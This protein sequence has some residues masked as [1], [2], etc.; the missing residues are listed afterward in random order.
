MLSLKK[1]TKNC[2]NFLWAIQKNAY[3]VYFYIK[4]AKT[5]KKQQQR[6]ITF[7]THDQYYVLIFANFQQN[8]CKISFLKHIKHPN[9]VVTVFMLTEN[10]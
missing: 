1:P 3:I 4:V 6:L 5:L 10:C 8:I 9:R 2:L 7:K